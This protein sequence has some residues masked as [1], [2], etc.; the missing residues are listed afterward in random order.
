MQKK[1]SLTHLDESDVSK[2]PIGD[3]KRGILTVIVAV[4]VE[5]LVCRGE[6]SGSVLQCA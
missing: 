2:S 1:T 4:V 5:S 6:K 3:R